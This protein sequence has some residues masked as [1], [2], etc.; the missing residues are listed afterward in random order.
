MAL[1]TD[2]SFHSSGH[3]MKSD[4]TGPY[5]VSSTGVVSLL[6]STIINANTSGYTQDNDGLWYYSDGSGPYVKGLDGMYL[7]LN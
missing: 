6:G 7:F 2:Y 1:P 4:G 3:I 5:S